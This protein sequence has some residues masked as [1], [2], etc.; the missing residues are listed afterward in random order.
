MMKAFFP[1]SA[2]DYCIKE[3]TCRCLACGEAFTEYIPNDYELVQFMC[4]DG[5]KRYLPT[6]GR[7]GYLSLLSNLVDGW[8]PNQPITPK[9]S[10]ALTARLSELC[11]YEVRLTDRS[12]LRCPRCGGAKISIRKEAVVNNLCV[13]WIEIQESFLLKM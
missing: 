12:Q 3:L 1:I 2:E 7:Y 5:K 10:G 11:P 13:D 8:T 9:I 6:Y 4:G